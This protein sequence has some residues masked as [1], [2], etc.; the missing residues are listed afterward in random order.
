VGLEWGWRGSDEVL[1]V[2]GEMGGWE[3]RLRERCGGEGVWVLCGCG[4]VFAVP[5]GVRSLHYGM[6]YIAHSNTRVVYIA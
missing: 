4:E 1:S 2:M 5:V 3:E 6:W